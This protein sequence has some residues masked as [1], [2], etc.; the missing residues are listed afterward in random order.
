MDTSVLSQELSASTTNGWVAELQSKTPG[1][2]AVAAAATHKLQAQY[3]ITKLL[4]TEVVLQQV[5]QDCV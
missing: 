2:A 3:D 4:N 1:D 5:T